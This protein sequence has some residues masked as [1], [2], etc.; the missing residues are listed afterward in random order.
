MRL[1]SCV[2][3]CVGAADDAGQIENQCHR[4]I[5]QNGGA[6]NPFHAPEIGIERLDH[7]LLLAEE[8]VPELA[9]PASDAFL[10]HHDAFACIRL[11]CD[12]EHFV[13]TDHGYVIATESKNFAA[14]GHLVQGAL[15]Q[16]QGFDD[17]DARHDVA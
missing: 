5:A 1:P 13:Q 6:G 15:T 9:C 12:A 2:N 3:P 8:I 14:P 16:F 7:H 17:A 11:P 10:Q 4:A